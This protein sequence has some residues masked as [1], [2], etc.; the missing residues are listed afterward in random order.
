MQELAELKF[1]TSC[2][3]V[4]V[5]MPTWMHAYKQQM[6]AELKEAVVLLVD[7][8]GFTRLS[9]Q[10]QGL[11][12]EGIDSLTNTINRM[13]TTIIE[14]VEAWGGDIVKFAG[15]AVIVIWE[16]DDDQLRDALMQAVN[17][18]PAHSHRAQVYAIVTTIQASPE[19]SSF[20]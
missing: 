14:H 10:F 2:V 3:R 6:E 18:S 8:S 15:D 4:R 20:Q 17:V 5:Q 1:T 16:T 19:K 9:D 12:Q 7:I 13:F 11:G